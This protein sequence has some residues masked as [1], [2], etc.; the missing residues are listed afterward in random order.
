MC[1]TIAAIATPNAPGGIGILRIS[2]ESAIIIA[3]RMFFQKET[4]NWSRW[5]GYSMHYGVI[6]DK[7]SAGNERIDEAICLV[8]RSPKSYTGEDVVEFSCHGGQ[9]I[10]RRVLRLALAAGARLAAPGEFTRRAFLNGRINL[11]EA[12]AVMRL[13]QA[14]TE[15]AARAATATLGGTLSRA[16]DEVRTLLIRQAAQISAWMDYPEDEP[17][18]LLELRPKQISANLAAAHQ[19]LH[20]LMQKSD[21]AVPLLDGVET[22]LIGKPNVGKSTLMNLLA[23]FE[24][25]IVTEFAGTTRDTVTEAVHLGSLPLRLTDTAGIHAAQNPIERLGVE[26][27]HAA[28]ASAAL[29]LLLLDA[30]QPLTEEDETLLTTCNPARTILL[31]NKADL[32]QAF[33]LAPLRTRFTHVIPF[34]AATGLGLEAL[35]QAIEA[36]LGTGDV[37][38]WEALLST[39]RQRGCAAD[40]LTALDAAIQAHAEG[41]PLDAVAVCIED[42]IQALYALTGERATEAIVDEVFATFCVGK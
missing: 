30:S 5:N 2:G 38:P 34:S 23:G 11:A 37:S 15:D 26:R 39:E 21:A 24:R 7:L 33:D 3:E 13:I 6:A 9:L 16:I 1:D 36:L 42:A 18:D 20:D 19:K 41:F 35:T 25:S 28:A 29:L 31:C 14:Q 4:I 27:S 10:L 32:G 8:F 22:V 17:T 12:E 40:A